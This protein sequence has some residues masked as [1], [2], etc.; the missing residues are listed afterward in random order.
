MGEGRGEGGGEEGREGKACGRGRK[1]ARERRGK[2]EEREEEETTTEAEG[3]PEKFGG[4]GRRMTTLDF[5][6]HLHIMHKTENSCYIIR[7][8]ITGCV[9][10]VE[11]NFIDL[12]RSYT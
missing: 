8:V 1:G 11:S 6:S 10:P 7:S 12:L 4:E 5:A 3:E 2:G 9:E